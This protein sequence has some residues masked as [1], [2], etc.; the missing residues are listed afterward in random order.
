[1]V[2]LKCPSIY[3]RINGLREHHIVVGEVV[4]RGCKCFGIAPN[5]T[6]PPCG[7]F[8]V[9]SP[10]S[11]GYFYLII[12]TVAMHVDV[13]RRRPL[14]MLTDPSFFKTPHSPHFTLDLVILVTTKSYHF[15]VLKKREACEQPVRRAVSSHFLSAFLARF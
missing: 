12:H 10:E 15:S 7:N 8:V 3:S 6:V 2:N 14:R 11:L 1:M 5:R 13:I 9:V 4:V